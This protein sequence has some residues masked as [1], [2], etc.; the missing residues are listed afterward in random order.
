MWKLLSTAYPED[1][2]QLE[3][4]Y[5]FKPASKGLPTADYLKLLTSDSSKWLTVLDLSTSFIDS[6]PDLVGVVGITNLAAF[7]IT[8]EPMMADNSDAL[9]VTLTDRVIRTWSE[10]AIANKAFKHLAILAVSQQPELTERVFTYLGD[11]EALGFFLV[12]GCPRFAQKRTR[13]LAEAHGWEVCVKQCPN[14]SFYACVKRLLDIMPGGNQESVTEIAS[15]PILEFSPLTP[16][17]GKTSENYTIIFKRKR[18]SSA[19]RGRDGREREAVINRGATKVTKRERKP[20]LKTN[21]KKDMR[22]LLGQFLR[23]VLPPP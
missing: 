8:S 20:V 12:Q 5:S 22:A 17:R 7:K 2:K 9:A 13:D 3:P 18:G 19:P 15:R 10:H 16:K 11:F 14:D 6:L 4:H 23:S 21:K 1:F